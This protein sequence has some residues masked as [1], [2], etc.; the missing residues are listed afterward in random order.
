MPADVD[1]FILLAKPLA[2]RALRL[3]VSRHNPS[4]AQ[5][6]TDFDDAIAAMREDGSFRAI[7]RKHTEGIAVLP[8]AR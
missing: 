4:A 1:R 8:G 7:V 2:R 3:G 6:I 5:I